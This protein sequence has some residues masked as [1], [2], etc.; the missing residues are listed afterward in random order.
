MDLT[1]I[2]D[3]FFPLPCISFIGWFLLWLFDSHALC[4][5]WSQGSRKLCC[6]LDMHIFFSFAVLSEFLTK[7]SPS[8]GP[9]LWHY[10]YWFISWNLDA[11]VTECIFPADWDFVLWF[12]YRYSSTWITGLISWY[13]EM[14]EIIPGLQHF[15]VAHLR[16]LMLIAPPTNPSPANFVPTSLAGCTMSAGM[17][18]FTLARA[19]MFVSFVLTKPNNQPCSKVISSIVI[20]SIASLILCLCRS[21]CLPPFMSVN[22]DLTCY[23]LILNL[24]AAP[25]Q[26]H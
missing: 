26:Q 8:K 17:S 15:W 13:R 21:S 11:C 23:W 9:S 19:P 14:Q 20:Q 4:W 3:F 10:D 2:Y 7:F 25:D 1:R 24:F 22:V 16:G 6:C 18:A 12:H 5:I